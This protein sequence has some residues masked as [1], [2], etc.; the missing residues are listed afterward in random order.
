MKWFTFAK[1]FSLAVLFA[2]LAFGQAA[3]HACVAKILAAD[4]PAF[5]SMSP[6][7]AF[8]TMV[9]V[10]CLPAPNIGEYRIKVAPASGSTLAPHVVTVTL[11]PAATPVWQYFTLI[12]LPS[13]WGNAAGAT[14]S[15]SQVTETNE[16]PAT[17]A[18]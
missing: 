3:N 7:P 13:T 2:A 8:N 12:Q 4:D 10:A 17:V 15:V 11:A 6:A 14:V 18:R 5:A 9:L 1:L 16:T